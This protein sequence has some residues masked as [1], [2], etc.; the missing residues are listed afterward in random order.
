MQVPAVCAS[1]F[2]AIDSNIN[3]VDKK[4]EQCSECGSNSVC[5]PCRS[6]DSQIDMNDIAEWKYFC[7]EQIILNNIDYIA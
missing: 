4:T 3:K 6:R 2:S 5:T 7:Q 1:K